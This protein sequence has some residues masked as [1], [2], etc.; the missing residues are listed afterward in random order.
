MSISSL[1]LDAFFTLARLGNFTKAAAELSITQSALSQRIFNLES[2]LETTL[3]IRD[4]AN[5]RLTEDGQTLLNYCRLREETEKDFVE[6]I[7]K[8]SNTHLGGSLRIGG[9]SSVMDS[10]ILESLST[11]LTQNQDIRVHLFKREI[12]D[13]PSLLKR[14]EIDLMILDRAF[15]HEDIEKL[16][17]GFE[18]NVLVESKEAKA[19]EVYLDHDEQD[20]VS[21]KYLRTFKMI[22]KGATLRRHFLDDIHGIIEGVKAGIGRAIIPK[23]LVKKEPQLKVLHADQIL[24]TPVFLHFHKMPFYSALHKAVVAEITKNSKKILSN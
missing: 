14:S 12:S 11:V 1:Q 7:R 24:K 20:E 19:P 4:R 5:L 23:H 9:F 18:E 6:K 10:V 16:L 8:K 17:L 21:E 2:D 22:S 3:V 15:D 13:L